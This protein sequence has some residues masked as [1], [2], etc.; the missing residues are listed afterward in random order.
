M[1]SA[2][3]AEDDGVTCKLTIEQSLGLPAGKHPRVPKIVDIFEAASGL[4]FYYRKLRGTHKPII[5]HREDNTL[6]ADFL[7]G[8]EWSGYGDTPANMA[9]LPISVTSRLLGVL[10]FAFNPRRR[11]QPEDEDFIN[12]LGL[13]ASATIALAIDRGEARERAEQ[14]TLQLQESEKQT[15]E[16]YQNALVG[17]IRVDSAGNII[18]ANRQYFEI[19]LGQPDG[20]RYEFSFMAPVR[21]EDRE[22]TMGMWNAIVNEQKSVTQE[23]R[24]NRTWTPPAMGNSTPKKEFCWLVAYAFPAL[25]NGEVKSVV[26]C[27]TDISRKK[28]AEEVQSRLAV[29]ATDAR[30][31][32]ESFI[33]YVSYEIRNPLSAILQLGESITETV[34]DG[35]ISDQSSETAQRLLEE[36]AES[37]RTILLCAAHQKRMVDDVLTLSKLDYQL[38]SIT[39]WPS[40]RWPSW[41]RH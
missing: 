33:D 40:N 39:P 7:E 20:D 32:Q 21:P 11:F 14:L 27:V 29:E 38:L 3:S 34:D 19:T 23:I 22:R 36:T 12:S 4:P 1:A 24:L 31:L 26:C 10:A 37:G 17:L 30:K 25:E 16:I 8:F 6:P 13:Q 41:S 18:Y 15:R 5:L 9:I 35:T 28:W 2:Y